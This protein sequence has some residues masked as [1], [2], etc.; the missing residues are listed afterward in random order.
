[1]NKRLMKYELKNTYKLECCLMGII[2]ALG[3][4]SALLGKTIFANK[5]LT[6]D[7]E[8]LM[9]YVFVD[10]CCMLCAFFVM[11]VSVIKRYYTIMFGKE[12]YMK[13][14]IPVDNAAHFNTNI[15]VG[16][17]WLAAGYV[18]MVIGIW[19]IDFG[20]GKGNEIFEISNMFNL[21]E[22]IRDS[23]MTG[24]QGV[25]I[26]LSFILVPIA[27]G[28]YFYIAAVSSISVSHAIVNKFNTTQKS[29]VLALVALIFFAIS[30]EILSLVTYLGY[31][32]SE[33]CFVSQFACIISE[34]LVI[35]ICV[36]AISALMYIVNR[37]IIENK[38][39]I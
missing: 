1:M 11:V 29:G 7:I 22:L 4:I 38:Y 9:Q 15:K 2:V 8:I 19:M 21:N 10:F 13:M 12:A 37:H 27:L 36:M 18:A 31:F 3:I 34:Y 23:D 25:M 17:M 32:V 33:H 14:A 20:L 16:V 24:F 6:G 39:N 28:L 35:E 30:L 5:I 26:I